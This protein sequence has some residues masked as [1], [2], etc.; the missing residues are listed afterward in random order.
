MD[1][2]WVRLLIF[3]EHRNELMVAERATE[4]AC[5]FIAQVL[6]GLLKHLLRPIHAIGQVPAAKLCRA[7]MAALTLAILVGVLLVAVDASLKLASRGM[8]ADLRLF[9]A[10]ANGFPGARALCGREGRCAD[11]EQQERPS[12][13]QP[14]RAVAVCLET[15]PPPAEGRNF[16]RFPL[17]KPRA[18]RSDK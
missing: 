7:L 10:G 16:H 1:R 11:D 2:L 14:T 5:L 8:A 3:A 15:P 4:I 6:G 18:H 9:E 12:R 17:W 13:H